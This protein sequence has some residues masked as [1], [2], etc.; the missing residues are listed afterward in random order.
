MR[1]MA[2]NMVF[3]LNLHQLHKDKVGLLFSPWNVMKLK[4]TSKTI[5]VCD[6]GLD[7][8]VRCL[9]GRHNVNHSIEPVVFMEAM[10]K[11]SAYSGLPSLRRSTWMILAVSNHF[12]V[13]HTFKFQ[14]ADFLLPPPN[15]SLNRSQLRL[16][17]TFESPTKRKHI[18]QGQPEA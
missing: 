9:H 12:S 14:N 18:L 17:P 10:G 2:G 13:F 16:R 3:I 8:H 7:P 4:T 15:P 5:A 11:D 1:V 6:Q